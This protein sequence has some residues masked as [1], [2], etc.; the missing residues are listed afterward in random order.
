MCCILLKTFLAVVPLQ[1]LR[2]LRRSLPKWISA[3]SFLKRYSDVILS[4]KNT[5]SLLNL[6]KHSKKKKQPH[7]WATLLQSIFKPNKCEFFFSDKVLWWSRYSSWQKLPSVSIYGH[8]RHHRTS[9]GRIFVQ[10]E[11]HKG[12][13]SPSSRVICD[14]GVYNATS[15][16]NYLCWTD[17]FRHYIQCRRWNYDNNHHNRMYG[18]RW[19]IE[20]G[21]NVWV[22]INGCGCICFG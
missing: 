17:C 22:F 18:I 9:W 11:I 15:L 21:L 5:V 2:F 6:V 1:T 10:S 13:I 7:H 12:P 8:F 20:K 19:R 4:L 14:R 16:G 3:E